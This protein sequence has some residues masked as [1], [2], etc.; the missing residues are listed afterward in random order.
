MG[1]F[2]DAYLKVNARSGEA[3]KQARDWLGPLVE[4]IGTKGCIGQIGE[5][6]EGDPPHRAVGCFAQAWSVGEVL[7]LAVELEM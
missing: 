6:Y 3:V 5:I 1:A 2:L 7:R 4:Q